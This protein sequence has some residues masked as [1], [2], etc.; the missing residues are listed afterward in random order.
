MIKASFLLFNKDNLFCCDNLLASFKDTVRLAFEW[1]I[2]YVL[3]DVLIKH[4]INYKITNIKAK[5]YNYSDMSKPQIAHKPCNWTGWSQ[6][7]LSFDII[8]NVIKHEYKQ[9]YNLK[10]FDST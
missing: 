7:L 8:T 4:T 5:W 6:S 10:I 1:A 3:L 2:E 9:Y